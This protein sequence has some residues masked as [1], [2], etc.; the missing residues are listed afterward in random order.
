[1]LGSSFTS[2]GQFLLS[3]EYLVMCGALGL[4]IPLQYQQNFVVI[5]NKQK[6]T[7]SIFWQQFYHNRMIFFATYNGNFATL[8][9]TDDKKKARR[10][11]NILIKIKAL[12][13]QFYG[14]QHKIFVKTYQNFDP[15]WG[16]GSSATLINNIAQWLNVDTFFLWKSIGIKGS[17]YDI[18]CTHIKNS[19]IYQHCPQKGMQYTIV[20]FNP[21]FADNLFFV[22]SGKKVFSSNA[23]KWF[24]K[25]CTYNEKDIQYISDITQQMVCC[26]TLTDFEMLIQ[27][28]EL[29]M[30]KILGIPR[31][32]KLFLDYPGAIKSLGA[33]GGDF[34][35]V[36]GNSAMQVKNY[37]FTKG[38]YVIKR[39]NDIVLDKG[40]S[41][42]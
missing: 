40:D 42:K 23:I 15:A 41:I 31:I 24:R 26:K 39:F 14:F 9:K 36:T 19:I 35:L 11:Q 29:K 32:G 5:S 20:H 25:Y 30:E 28:H 17:G 34:F 13:P 22:Y 4:A 27:K 33:W 7:S 37:F 2:C 38:Y 21:P 16:L 6:V 12:F 1:M 8:V 10:L 3:G 18:V